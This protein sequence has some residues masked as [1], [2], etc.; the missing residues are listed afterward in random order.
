MTTAGPTGRCLRND[1]GS[2]GWEVISCPEEPPPASDCH[3]TG[4]SGQVC[5]DDDVIT[6]CEWREEYA[7]YMSATCE[8]QSDG[9]CG[10]TPTPELTACLG[11]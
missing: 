10:W 9:R 7:C 1:D 3:P 2:C 6:T 8:R 4:C 11:G 5:A